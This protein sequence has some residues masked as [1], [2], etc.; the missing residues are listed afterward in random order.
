MR[1]YGGSRVCPFGRKVAPLWTPDLTGEKNGDQ[2]QDRRGRLGQRPL[3]DRPREWRQHLRHALSSSG[4]WLQEE[5]KVYPLE[6]HTQDAGKVQ[7]E[8]YG[9]RREG[10][11][12]GSR[13]ARGASGPERGEAR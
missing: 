10:P 8:G 4:Q 6:H 3:S 1:F 5:T 7:Q 13:Q 2:N 12:C 9:Q 11:R